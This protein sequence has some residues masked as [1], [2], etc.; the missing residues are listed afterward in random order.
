MSK[1]NGEKYIGSVRFFK[2]MILL[3]ILLVIATLSYF[4]HHY[5]AKSAQ[6]ELQGQLSKVYVEE[7]FKEIL[8]AG[9]DSYIKFASESPSYQKLYPDFYAPK[10]LK[11][12][13]FTDKTVYLTFDDGPSENTA[14]IL[15]ILEQEN[16]KA[17]FFVIGKTDERS[18]SLMR[19]I[20]RRGHT[21]GMHTFSHKYSYIYSSVENYLK[22][23]YN[24]FSLIKK[25]TGIT[26]EVFRFPGGSLNN[27]NMQLY[28]EIMAEMLRRGF[29]PFD[30]DLST[31]DAEGK[32]LTAEMMSE[33]IRQ[34]SHRTTRPV[35]LMH[36]SKNNFATAQAVKLI[37]DYFKEQ[38]YKFDKLTARTKPVLFNTYFRKEE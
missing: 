20:V 6:L 1:A 30:W 3:V 25:S 37:I 18:I 21:L 16:I 9:R 11:S 23:M 32:K 7:V 35:I 33:N 34:Q 26:P 28:R 27:Q 15:D 24:I 36:D 4:V 31:G 10:V 17:T 14:K 22:D 12:G 8:D 13:K 29:V 2:N 38:G 5:A 19:E